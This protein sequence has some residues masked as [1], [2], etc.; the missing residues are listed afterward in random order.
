M[1]LETKQERKSREKIIRGKEINS[2]KKEKREGVKAEE[3]RIKIAN[4]LIGE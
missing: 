1:Y 3:E 2:K 4:Y